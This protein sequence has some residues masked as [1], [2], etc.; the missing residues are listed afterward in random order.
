ML[1]TDESPRLRS[2]LRCA[3]YGKSGVFDAERLIDVMQA[4]ENF[5]TAAKSGGGEDPN[6]DMVELGFLQIQRSNVPIFPF[7]FSSSQSEQPI[8][9]RAALAF[10]LS[11]KGNFF[12]EFLLDELVFVVEWVSFD[13]NAD[14]LT[15]RPER[16]HEHQ[17]RSLV[18]YWGTRKAQKK[19][20]KNKEIR[21]KKTL[22]HITGRKPFSVVQVEETN[23]KNG[24]PAT[25]LEVWM[26]GYSKDNKLSNDKV[27][28]VMTQMK[29]L[30]AQSNVTD[31]EIIM[32]VLGPERPS[33]VRTYG[34]GPSPTDVFRGGYTQS[35]EQTRIIQM[36]V[37]EQ[38]NQY[39]AQMEMQIKEMIDAM[40]NQQKVQMEMQGTIQDQ[41]ERI[42]QWEFTYQRKK[43]RSSRY[44]LRWN[45]ERCF[46]ESAFVADIF[47]IIGLLG[48][49]YSVSARQLSSPFGYLKLEKSSGFMA[50]S[51]PNCPPFEFATKYYSGMGDS[52]VTQSSFFGGKVVL[53]QGVWYSV[54]L[55]FG[56]FFA[57]FTSF[58]VWYSYRM[59]NCCSSCFLTNIIVMAMLL[60]GGSAV[61][62]CTHWS[63]HLRC[64]FFNPTWRNCLHTCRGLKA[65]FLASY[66]H[67]VIVHVVL[68]VFVYLVYTSSSKL[69]SPSIVYHCLLE[70][71][72]KSRVCQEPLTHNGQSC[73]PVS[74]NYKGSYLTMLSSGALVFGII[75]IVGN[76]VPF[77]LT[78]AAKLIAVS[79]L[80]TYDIHR[81]HI[82]PDATGKQIFSV[83]RGVV[84]GF[85]CFMG[86]LVVI[87]NKARVSLGWMYLAMGVFIAIGAILG[88]TI[89]CILGIITWLSVVSVEYGRVNLD[90]TGRNALMLAGNLVSI[91]TCGAIHA[92]CSFLWPQN[93]D[94]D[95]TK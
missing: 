20:T 88:T 76:F 61:N 83:S 84:L 64:K 79:S 56:A 63:E 17:W 95:T 4:F 16:V 93:Y 42:E 9:T 94:W 13:N 81:T 51:L 71:P 28:A 58:L 11:E 90:T 27:D 15:H 54:I 69:G 68:V 24:V 53:N 59:G 19:S 60:L 70:V 40:L 43:R 87:L 66:I 89:G 47:N 46:V 75:N 77:L 39:K 32:Q 10:L 18:Y 65:T 57:I 52:C 35:Q 25:R 50:S 36:Q 38:L 48:L 74:G 67:S 5:R 31:E 78:I 12:R 37:Q 30:G 14:R 72:S 7:P 22:N 80:C 23:K 2:A 82:N 8:Q 41:Q 92:V 86:L 44:K 34:L 1:L 29:D 73:G 55:G 85:G 62:E 26:A 45:G 3:I 91:L 49:I 33:R 6:R 21:K